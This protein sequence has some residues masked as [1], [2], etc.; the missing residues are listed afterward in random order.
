MN[1]KAVAVAKDV[2]KHLKA[3]RIAQGYYINGDALPVMEGDLKDNLDTVQKKCRVC[4][5]GACVLSKA[6]LYD[7]V[8]LEELLFDSDAG[9]SLSADE[10]D[11]RSILQDVFDPEQMDL[12]E[13]AFEKTTCLAE[14]C[15]DYALLVQ[16]VDFGN[17]YEDRYDRVK[18]VMEN[19]IANNGKFIVNAEVTV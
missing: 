12:M 4:L 8:P 11:T 7:N 1:E 19:I 17:R 16:A 6:R 14:D 9:K 3:L 13:A 18:A 10:D 15:T 2:L 5:L